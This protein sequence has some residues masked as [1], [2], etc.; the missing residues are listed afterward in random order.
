VSRESWQSETEKIGVSGVAGLAGSAVVVGA[1]Q[2]FGLHDGV[3]VCVHD[4]FGDADGLEELAVVLD[5]SA[6][7][8]IELGFDGAFAEILIEGS[9][10]TPWH[11]S[12][13]FLRE[14]CESRGLHAAE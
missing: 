11:R 2:I 8:G 6:S 5:A 14:R 7:P 1:E 12:G 9:I 4:V 13:P 10:D 3:R